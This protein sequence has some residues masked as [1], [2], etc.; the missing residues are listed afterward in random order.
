MTSTIKQQEHSRKTARSM[1]FVALALLAA[2]LTGCPLV[3]LPDSKVFSAT[4]LVTVSDGMTVEVP[5][6]AGAPSLADSTWA[7]H[8]TDDD[9]LLFRI[10]FGS[11]GE[12]ERLF[13]S[14]VFAEGWLG[15]EII[16]DTRARP[17][18]FPGGS[19]LSGA[20]TA[21]QDDS[22]GVLGVLHGLLLS[23][24]LGTATLSFS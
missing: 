7:V 24:H 9:S 1:G 3:G 12:V 5:L 22:V 19:Y 2:G 6:G 13:Y 18:E 20:Y 11:N 21:E 14:F 15:D 8:R 17:S 16:P 23:S 10:T 4:E